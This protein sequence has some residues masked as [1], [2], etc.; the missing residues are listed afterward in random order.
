LTIDGRIPA[1]AYAVT[2]DRSLPIVVWYHGGGFVIGD[3]ETADRICR[4]LAIG[5]GA[6][7]ISIDYALAPERPFPAG[8]DDCFAAL[9]WIIENAESLGGDSSRVAIGGDSAGGNMAAV[10]AIRARDAGI[11]LRH[12]LLV[13]PVTDCTM[14][15]TSYVANAEGYLLTADSMDWFIGHYLSGGADAKDPRVSPLYADDLRGLAPAL[16]ITAEF[17]PLRDEGEAYGERLE[18]AGNDVVLRRF[19]GQIHGFFPL[20]AVIPA[21]NDAVT[22]A[23]DHLKAALA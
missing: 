5:T 23:V 11:A 7:V 15:S 10:T 19:D 3:L 16:V 22:L 2:T 14:T 17:D 6:L 8:P 13:Y 21:A 1:R 9:Q 20:G 4:K 18:E 12:Q